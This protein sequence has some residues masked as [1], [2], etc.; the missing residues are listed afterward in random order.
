[1]LTHR[2]KLIRRQK[3]IQL[4]YAILWAICAGIIVWSI[5]ITS[6]AYGADRCE[7]FI[8]DVR[9][10][11]TKYFGLGFPYWYGLGQLKQESACRASV[12]AFAQ[13]MG[14]AQFMPRTSTYIQSLM[15]EKLDP[16]NP[17]QAVRMQAFYMNRIHRKEN[18][19]DRLWVDYQ[20]YNGGRGTLYNEFVRAG[21]LDWELMKL[22]CQRKK[23]Q[24][25]WGVLD[26][27]VV[28]YSYPKQVYKYG[29][30]YRR[31]P[32]GYDFW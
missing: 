7:S 2:E 22:S 21:V 12:T 18:W 15:G 19:S 24:M 28:S 10:E 20:I 3:M 1:M 11:H 17:K 5:L 13:G 9:I 29:Q 8:K 25:K 31:G 26:L 4:G 32:D 23:I 27:C 14:A 16:Y 6:Q 30:Q